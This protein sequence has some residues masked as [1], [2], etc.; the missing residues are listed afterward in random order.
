MFLLV[1][2]DIGICVKIEKNIQTCR[3]FG[4]RGKQFDHISFFGY[5][6]W[7]A[8]GTGQYSSNRLVETRLHR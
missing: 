4:G 2:R 7:P 1:A 3:K 5:E 6:T 8:H